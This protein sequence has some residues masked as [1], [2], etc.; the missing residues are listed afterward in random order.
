LVSS[1]GKGNYARNLKCNCHTTVYDKEHFKLARGD[2]ESNP[3]LYFPNI[4]TMIIEK[5]KKTG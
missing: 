3:K 5:K 2:R 4:L 1:T